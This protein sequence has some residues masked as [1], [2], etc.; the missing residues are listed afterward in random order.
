MGQAWACQG[1]GWGRACTNNGVGERL[2][3]LLTHSCVMKRKT[4]VIRE[5]RHPGVGWGFGRPPM[6]GCADQ[7]ERKRHMEARGVTTLL[8]HMCVSPSVAF[9]WDRSEPP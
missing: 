4:Q 9:R 7:W 6:R 8:R 3:V 1:W 2:Q 5:G